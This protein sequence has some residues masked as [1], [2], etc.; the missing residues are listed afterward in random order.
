MECISINMREKSYPVIIKKGLANETLNRTNYIITDSNVAR[1]YSNLLK[2]KKVIVIPAGEESKSIENYKDLTR[3]LTDCEEIT[4]FGGG[5]VGDLAGFVAATLRRGIKLTQVPTTLLAMVDASIG[6]KNGI[7]L[8]NR[9]NY[10]GT[11]YQPESVK[12]DPDVLRTLPEKEIANGVAEMIKYG[13]IKEEYFLEKMQNK[14]SI[15]DEDLEEIIAKAAD[16][17]K[18]FIERDER[19]ENIRHALNFGHTIGHALELEYSISH[20]EAV[21]IGMTYESLLFLDENK[22]N[23]II[24]ALR[25]NNLPT[26]LPENANIDKIINL[27]KTDKKGAL[28]FAFNET[29]YNIQINENEIRKVLKN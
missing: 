16:T 14:F 5:V 26:K 27:M 24:T 17:K 25:A 22:T 7:N 1:I 12:I 19:D 2:N 10:L 6:G 29:N 4:A 23:K 3:K 20:G 21:S 9:K 15:D 28:T 11:I 13:A 8:E 18:Y